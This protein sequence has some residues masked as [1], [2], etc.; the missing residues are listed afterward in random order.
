MPTILYLN[1]NKN[2]ITFG[3]KEFGGPGSG[4][5]ETKHPRDPKGSNTGGHFKS[6]G[7]GPGDKKSEGLKRIQAV[8]D[9]MDFPSSRVIM[10]TEQSD[11]DN[12]GRQTVAEYVLADGMIHVYPAIYDEQVFKIESVMAHEIAHAKTVGDFGLPMFYA[13]IADAI[14]FDKF[15]KGGLKLLTEY[16]KFTNYQAVVWENFVVERSAR[17]GRPAYD[18]FLGETY[19]ELA[20][21]DYEG[22]LKKIEIDPVWMKFYKYTNRAIK[23]GGN[24]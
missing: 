9:K 19:A 17:G 3:V 23:S 16:D 12:P 10:E 15:E 24:Q 6:K 22:E 7:K 13:P 1:G 2:R 20:R 18:V 11:D 4:F 8:M 21:L 14:G 5:D